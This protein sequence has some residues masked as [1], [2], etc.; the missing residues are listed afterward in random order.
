MISWVDV[1]VTDPVIAESLTRFDKTLSGDKDNV[2]DSLIT[3]LHNC[4]RS[5]APGRVAC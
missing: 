1:T 4:E 2:V 5:Q 3:L